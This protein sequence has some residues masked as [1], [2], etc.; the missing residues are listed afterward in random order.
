LAEQELSKRNYYFFKNKSIPNV[1]IALNP[2]TTSEQAKDL[3]EQIEI[4]Y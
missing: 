2:E 4:K 3:K 1:I